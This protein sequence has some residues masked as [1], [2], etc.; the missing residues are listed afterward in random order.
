MNLARDPSRV[1]GISSSPDFAYEFMLITEN[2]PMNVCSISGRRTR[3]LVAIL[4]LS[5]A[6]CGN[7]NNGSVSLGVGR[8]DASTEA[9]LPDTGGTDDAGH[10]QMMPTKPTT[11]SKGTDAG[12]MTSTPQA[13]CSP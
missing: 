8:M 3:V 12:A 2:C 5:A 1:L 13:P 6:R 4:A 11:P 9:T 7:G 10:S